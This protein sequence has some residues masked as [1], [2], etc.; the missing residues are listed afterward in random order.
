MKRAIL[1]IVILIATSSVA[2]AQGC[3]GG[4]VGFGFGFNASP[5]FAGPQFGG[6]FIVEQPGFAGGWGG[7]VWNPGWNGWNTGQFA[8]APAFAPQWG[9]GG[10]NGGWGNTWGNTWGSPGFN[11][12]WNGGWGWG[13]NR[14]WGNTFSSSRFSFRSRA[15][16][17]T[18]P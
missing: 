3:W 4:G 18:C 9:G 16:C 12:G 1:S 5:Q 6:S 8:T 2:S 7:G 14:A 17:P 10:W 15:W 11:S 13:G